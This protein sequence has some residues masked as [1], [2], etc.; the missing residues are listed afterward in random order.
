[1]S[2]DE[3]SCQNCEFYKVSGHGKHGYCLR[4]PPV[5][6]HRDEKTGHPRF[7]SPVVSPTG[8]C[9]EYM[10]FPDEAQN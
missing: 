10:E 8:W 6:T 4:Y 1:M 9:G 7:Y 3:V 2:E 5:F